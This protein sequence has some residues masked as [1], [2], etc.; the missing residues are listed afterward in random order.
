MG[1]GQY[2]IPSKCYRYTERDL[3]TIER[4]ELNRL[5]EAS[6]QHLIA[7]MQREQY[8]DLRSVTKIQKIFM[9]N[10]LVEKMSE[11]EMGDVGGKM[12]N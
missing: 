3:K 11:N 2:D 6:L 4:D 9:K 5:N 1:N 10:G 12:V 8:Y 7:Y